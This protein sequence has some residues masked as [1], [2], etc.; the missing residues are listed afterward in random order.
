M[1]GR[2]WS[3]SLKAIKPIGKS[4]FRPR[5]ETIAPTRGRINTICFLIEMNAIDIQK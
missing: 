4:D 5:M 3:N 1:W 2:K